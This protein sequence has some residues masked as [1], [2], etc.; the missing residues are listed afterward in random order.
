MADTFEDRLAVS[1][2]LTIK[3]KAHAIPPGNIQSVSLE[4]HGWG[5]E[6]AVE[7]LLTDNSALGGKQK[8]AL[9]KPFLEPDLVEVSLDVSAVQTD[10][11]A[12]QKA[13]P[14]QLKALVSSKSLVELPA[15]NAPT[16]PLLHR[17]Y[18][19]R[20][21][22]PARLLWRQ[23]HPCALYTEKT[24]KDVLEEHKGEKIALTYDWD[25][26]LGVTHPLLFV[27]LERALGASFYDLLL[28][29]VDHHRGVLAY[30]AAKGQYSLLG[31]KSE[32][33]KPVE[34][35]FAEVASLQVLLPDVLR[36]DATV[37]NAVA[38][39]P[40]KEAL[41]QK[42]AVKGLRQDVLMC[43]PL[44]DVVQARVD[45]EQA[46]LQ[47]RGM[48]LELVWRR[49]PALAFAPN[50]LVKLPP[51][52]GWNPAGAAGQE[53]FRVRSLRLEARATE[54]GPDA[55]RDAPHA[56]FH[57]Q[58][59]TRLE[60]QAETWIDLPAYTA[61]HYPRYVEGLTVSEAG[62]EKHETWQVYS[63][64]KTNLECYHV[65][66]PI[67]EDQVVHPPFNPNL[68]PGHFYFPA[69]K[70]E[71]VLVALDFQRCWVK[72]FLDW[73]ASAR[74]PQESQG[75]QLLMGKTPQNGATLQ[76]TYEDDK[77]ILLIQRTNEKDS[78]TIRVREGGMRIQ[79]KE[80]KG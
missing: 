49:M 32:K 39:G 54:T 31:A 22:D 41:T 9:L 1:L 68:Q 79:I 72:R 40:K 67:F 13:T 74:L 75:V 11:K 15:T 60:R 23:H 28:W 14:L 48:E 34:L 25:A 66:L 45:L 16:S 4:M 33:G 7:F 38:E 18:S 50:A 17:R 47:A 6:G 35:E 19:L 27:G 30:D 63:E 77:P 51:G 42:Q 44:A 64:D 76:Q 69:Y 46:R 52:K 53:T 62:E 57:F 3:G 70:E 71:R 36:H 58:M 5:L 78:G 24:F 73:R 61:P 65:K 56:G 29:Y 20:F 37:L 59:S 10:L 55:E 43:T 21:T 26:A 8:D 12:K 80:E 2:T